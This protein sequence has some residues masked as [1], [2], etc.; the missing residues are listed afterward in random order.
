[1]NKRLYIAYGSNLNTEQMRWR[2]PGSKVIAKSWM[3]GWRL[4]FQGAPFGAHANVIPEADQDVPVVIWE[5]T[6]E[7]ERA[8]DRYEG[9]AGG[10]YSKVTMTIE[11]AGEMKDALIYIMTPNP[12]GIPADVYLETIAEGYK[13]FNLDVRVLNEAVKHAQK[14]T[15][16]SYYAD[17]S[18]AAPAT[19]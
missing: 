1:M 5:I 15:R 8:L 12:Y 11:V 3:H 9:V 19:M 13:E 16:K 18:A 14:N 7:D 2:C 6:P 17:L 4:V 10:Y